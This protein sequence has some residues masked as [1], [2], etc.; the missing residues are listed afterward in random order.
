M[1]RHSDICHTLQIWMRPNSLADG[2][3]TGASGGVFWTLPCFMFGVDFALHQGHMQ[4]MTCLLAMLCKMIGS[5]LQAVMN[6]DGPHLPWPLL[7]TGQQQGCGVG[8]TAESDGEGQGR[9]KTGRQQ[10]RASC[11]IIC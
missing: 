3:I 9:L 1:L 4:L 2:A 10:T 5:L 8:T 11:R 7:N 6:V